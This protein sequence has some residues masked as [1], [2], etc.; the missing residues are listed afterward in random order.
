MLVFLGTYR[1]SSRR[2]LLFVSSRSAA[3]PPKAKSTR[4]ALNRSGD[5]LPWRHT[6]PPTTEA[7]SQFPLNVC[8]N[9]EIKVEHEFKSLRR[10]STLGQN[11]PRLHIKNQPRM[12]E[13]IIAVSV[14]SR[15]G[16]G[17]RLFLL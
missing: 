17:Y 15:L 3:T 6:G 13:K 12:Q 5:T 10:T 9:S 16:K 2:I 7:L 4:E 11:G 1:M 14:E 8:K